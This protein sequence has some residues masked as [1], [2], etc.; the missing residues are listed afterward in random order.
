MNCVLENARI[1]TS[2]LGVSC[3]FDWRT[4]ERQF[5]SLPVLFSMDFVP[6]SPSPLMYICIKPGDARI[7]DKFFPMSMKITKLDKENRSTIFNQKLFQSEEEFK[8]NAKL[9]NFRQRLVLGLYSIIQNHFCKLNLAYLIFQD[10]KC[11]QHN[12][13]Q[14]I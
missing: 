6:P 8:H 13:K 7:G 3:S 11:N 9:F 10:K 2:Q 14:S 12:L 4:T 5:F 1:L